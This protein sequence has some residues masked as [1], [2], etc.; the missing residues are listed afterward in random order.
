ME[1][2]KYSEEF[3]RQVVEQVLAV[4]NAS[5]VARKH[6]IHDSVVGRWVRQ[7]QA[8]KGNFKTQTPAEQRE[9]DK[10]NAQ[11]K[12]LLG[13]K[14]LEIAILRDLLKKANPHLRIK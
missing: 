3:K 2:R 11:L 5:V 12:K 7:A 4:G 9:L 8:G 10:E 1:R 13:E 14:D 6:N